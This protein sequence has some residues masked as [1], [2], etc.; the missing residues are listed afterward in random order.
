MAAC[1]VVAVIP[2]RGGSKGIP[3]KNL[4]LLGGKTL[5]QRSIDCAQA[6]DSI[7]DVVVT[8]DSADISAHAESCGAKVVNRPP[9]LSADDSLVI[10]AIRHTRDVL[11]SRGVMHQVI[12]LLEPTSPLRLPGDVTACIQLLVEHDLDSV[13][14]FAEASLNPHRAWRLSDG[15]AA[16]FIEGAIPWTRRQ[17]LPDAYELNGAVYAFRPDLLDRDG[18][19]LL[20]GN[21][22]GIVMPKERSID[23]DDEID[24]AVTE[25]LLKGPN[26]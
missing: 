17:D 14:T 23:I 11:V 2:A 19:G 9:E 7:D 12:V 3:D 1:S 20:G 5:L 13:A 26:P 15:M 8:T 6:V 16:P 25:L 21:M 10:D 22:S 18:P 4:R 24:L